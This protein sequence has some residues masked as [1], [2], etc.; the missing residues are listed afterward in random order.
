MASALKKAAALASK[1]RAAAEPTYNL[2]RGETVKRYD[3]LMAQNAQARRGGLRRPGAARDP[4][5]SMR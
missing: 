3:Q 4:R 2:V 1:A 5:R